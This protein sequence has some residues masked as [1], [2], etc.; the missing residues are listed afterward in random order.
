MS[1][2]KVEKIDV[3]ICSAILI[4]LIIM[5]ILVAF[6]V[7][8]PETAASEIPIS[9]YSIEETATETVLEPTIISETINYTVETELLVPETSLVTET[10]ETTYICT[11]SPTVTP[12]STTISTE[13]VV[14]PI[15]E[16]EEATESVL[17]A[18]KGVNYNINGNRETWYNLN[19][20]GV[21]QIMR[22]NGFS[23]E[24]YP[25]WIRED[26]CKM[27]GPYIMV[28]ANHSIYPRGTTIHTSLGEGLVCDTGSFIYSYP[29]GID[30]ATNW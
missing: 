11:P 17:T 26:G 8:E 28:A 10:E 21:I 19:M 24:D 9:V 15:V 20:S 29:Y 3:F 12:I 16:S 6:Q 1:Q 14:E 7:T 2:N 22:D 18:Q 27:L 5:G 4:T 13:C 23:E 30:I 25:Y